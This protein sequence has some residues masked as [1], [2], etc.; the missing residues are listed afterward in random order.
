MFEDFY[1]NKRVF[2]TGHTGFKG[3]WLSLWLAELGAH[4]H[5]YSLKPPTE[6]SL[7]EET[8]IRAR[9]ASHQIADV[10]DAESLSGAIHVAKPDIVFHLAAQ[11]LVRRSYREPRQTYETN[12]MGTVNLLDAIRMTDS[13]RVCQIITS[14]K[15][16]E[17]REWLYPYR[18][19]EPMGGADPYSSSK[20]CAELV[21]SAYR[22]SFFDPA[23]VK[24]H[25][26]SLASARAGNVIGGGDWAEDR[27]IPDC[28]RALSK[29]EV[30]RVRNPDA[31]RPWQ[32]VLEPLAGYLQLA[33]AQYAD[34]VQFAQAWNFGPTETSHLTVKQVVEEV[35]HCWGSGGW[36]CSA[37][38]TQSV[39]ESS[40]HEATLLKLDISKASNL[41]HWR[42]F[43]KGV[44][45]ISQ[46]VLWYRSRASAATGF[47]ASRVCAAQIEAY[48]RLASEQGAA[49]ARS[50][51]D[52]ERDGAGARE[53]PAVPRR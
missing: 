44:E 36:Q 18:E 3:T 24:Q 52:A 11:A 41:L 27:I 40:L 50:C 5:G 17:N 53:L 26:V 14:D 20:G 34:P 49:W 23:R 22:R 6:P 1:R 25:G 21:V 19:N 32:H 2:V 12:V 38:A 9:L 43:W 8:D 13:V 42:P 28:I 15:C 4:V 47:N 29:E 30:I 48:A 37:P 39:S 45:A 33:A 31:I 16:Y 46:T 7:F 10:R 35:I 51:S